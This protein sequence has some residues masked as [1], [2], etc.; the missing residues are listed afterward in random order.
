MNDFTFSLEDVMAENARLLTL[1]GELTEALES[2]Q[3]GD[4]CYCDA[5]FAGPGTI[6]RHTDECEVAR[7]A[8][9][10]A[11]GEARE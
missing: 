8:L 1:A 4:G 6:V 2:L 7:A 10:K 9:A 3:H 5:A 11:R